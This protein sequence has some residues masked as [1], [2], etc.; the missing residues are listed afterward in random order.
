MLLVACPG[1]D[2]G[3]HSRVQKN[4]SPT[5]CIRRVGLIQMLVCVDATAS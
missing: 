1:M 4:L 2:P 5:S 3:R